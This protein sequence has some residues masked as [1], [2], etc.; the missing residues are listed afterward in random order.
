VSPFFS[1]G[2]KIKSTFRLAKA[3]CAGLVIA[4]T[5]ADKINYLRMKFAISSYFEIRS[6]P[7]FLCL[8]F[9][10]KFVLS[11]LLIQQQKLTNKD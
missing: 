11:R 1:F 8:A 6:K 7:A 5:I 9:V 4:L 3:L 2:G 10:I